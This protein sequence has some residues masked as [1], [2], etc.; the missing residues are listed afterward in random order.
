[1]TDLEDAKLLTPAQL[2]GH[3]ITS[4]PH[5]VVDEQDLSDPR[6]F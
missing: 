1:M 6:V 3:R 4:F 5:I 2:H